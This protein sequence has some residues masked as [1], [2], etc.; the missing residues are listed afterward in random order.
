[1]SHACLRAAAIR[2]VLVLILA[3]GC[4]GCGAL[5]ASRYDSIR[6]TRGIA[7]HEGEDAHP[8]RHQLDVYSPIGPGPAPVLFFVHAGGWAVGGKNL[9]GYYGALGEQLARHGVVAVF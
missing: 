7:Y 2:A 1:M 8:I 4:S 6:I 3:A 9:V 5:G